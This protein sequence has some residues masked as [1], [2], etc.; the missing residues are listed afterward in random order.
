MEVKRGEDVQHCMNM[1]NTEV[2]MSG[3][4]ISRYRGHATSEELP[5]EMYNI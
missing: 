3:A 2:E 1:C 5:S 4:D